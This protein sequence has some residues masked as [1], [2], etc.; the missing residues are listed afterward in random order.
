M[1]IFGPTRAEAPRSSLWF[2]ADVIARSLCDGATWVVE[3]GEPRWE[4][5]DQEL[6]RMAGALKLDVLKFR[7]A[8]TGETARKA[9]YKQS[10]LGESANVQ[11]TPTFFFVPPSGKIKE[12]PFK[13]LKEW[14]AK[15]KNWTAENASK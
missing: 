14:L 2:M 15:D 5:A 7:S 6:T 13:M 11:G 1:T 12:V 3:G 10:E 8:L 4:R 9:V